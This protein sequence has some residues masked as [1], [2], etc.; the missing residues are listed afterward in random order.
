MI[1]QLNEF[2]DK[3]DGQKYKTVKIGNQIWMAENLNFETSTGSWAYNDEPSNAKNFGR[4]YNW[5]TACKVCPK[6]WHLPS[7]K[8]WKELEMYVGIEKWEIDLDGSERGGGIFVGKKLRS[9]SGWT[10]EKD[11]ST[12]NE[13]GFSVVAGG[14]RSV[15]GD[16]GYLGE[17]ANFW[18]STKTKN[19]YDAWKRRFGGGGIYRGYDDKRSGFSVRCIKNKKLF[20]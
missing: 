6:G 11:G 17:S 19:K 16:Y 8:E 9:K 20:C 7:D 10:R 1:N 5:E 2:I 14:Y 12:N 3:R 18:T 15:S 13:T 4:L